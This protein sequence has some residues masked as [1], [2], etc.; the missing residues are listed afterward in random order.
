MR[1]ITIVYDGTLYTY[2]WIK[3]LCWLKKYFKK[4]GFKISYL[5]YRS[6]FPIANIASHQIDDLIKQLNSK[7]FDV[8]AIAFHHS[9]SDFSNCKGL[10]KLE[11]L[12]LLREHSRRIVW[13]DTADSTGNC[14]FEVLPYVDVY[15]KKQ[16][17]KDLNLYTK[18]L[19]GSK[20]FIDYYHN[21]LGLEDKDIDVEYT[22]LQPEY[23]G[24]VKLAWNIGISDFWTKKPHFSILRPSQIPVPCMIPVERQRTT[25]MF[26]NGTLNYTPITGYQRRIT[27]EMMT[28]ND[29]TKQPSPLL[30][31]SHKQYVSFMKDAK[32]VI[33]PFGW[34]EICYRDFE[35][36]TYGA[37]LIK[38][39][40]DQVS[41]YPNLFIKGETYVPLNW[42]YTNFDEIVENIESSQYKKIA[43]AGQERYSH[44]LNSEEG[45]RNIAEHI[46]SVF[47][48]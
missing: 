26:F 4:E 19:Y 25:N 39:D 5:N 13:L 35:A 10:D 42:D 17:Y 22:L 33:S 11:F 8:V 27:I 1:E 30:K 23:K 44:Y 37:T 12:K 43:K 31:M 28:K 18:H 38:P 45:K 20:L 16:L 48:F 3:T 32:T 29:K 6:L 47:L 36:F 15:L 21:K 41:T 7:R 46:L 40:M 9:K 24:K 34:G 2:Q 14:Q